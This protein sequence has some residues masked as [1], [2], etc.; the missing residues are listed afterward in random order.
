MIRFVRMGP[1]T[2]FSPGIVTV[3]NREKYLYTQSNIQ[4]IRP[5]GFEVHLKY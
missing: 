5:M 4:H 1:H 3:Y 2:T